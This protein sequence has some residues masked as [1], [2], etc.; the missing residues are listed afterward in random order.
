M[1]QI[2]DKMVRTDK[3]LTKWQPKCV[4]EKPGICEIIPLTSKNPK[5][6]S[7]AINIHVSETDT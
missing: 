6:W 2:R 3:V 5:L 7:R 4:V 1:L